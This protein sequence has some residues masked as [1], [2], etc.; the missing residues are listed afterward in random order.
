MQAVLQFDHGNAREHD[1]GFSVL[2]FERGQLTGL[3]SR[4]AAISTP[5]SRTDPVAAD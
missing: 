1:L 4:S 5:E 3:A 2:G